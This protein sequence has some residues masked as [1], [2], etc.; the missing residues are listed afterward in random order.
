MLIDGFNVACK[1]ISASYLKVGDESMSVILFWTIEKGDLPK[2]SYIL[3]KPDPLGKYFNKVA[4]SITGDLLLIEVKRGKEGTNHSNYQKDLGSTADCTKRMSEATKGMGQKY[5]KG[6]T[7]DCLI[8]DGWF[9]SKK[10]VEST[11][12]VGSELIGMVKTNTK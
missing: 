5:R 9:S 4:C 6:A 1:N 7:N 10:A 2:L 3:R 12:E 11:M 8:F